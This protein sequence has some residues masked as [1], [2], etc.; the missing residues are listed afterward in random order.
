MHESD[1]ASIWEMNQTRFTFRGDYRWVSRSRIEIK[2]FLSVSLY[3][4]DGEGLS[5]DYLG[6]YR[7]SLS[8]GV[9]LRTLKQGRL[10]L[11][12]DNINFR[13]DGEWVADRIFNC[14]YEIRL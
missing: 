8:G 10:S 7:N 4:S 14:R 1:N 12:Y 11:R 6:A 13:R 9:M 2:P 3:N 5:D